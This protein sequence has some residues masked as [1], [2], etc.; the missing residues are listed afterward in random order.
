LATTV[1]DLLT[2]FLKTEVHEGTLLQALA[3]LKTWSKHFTNNLPASF[4]STI[5]TS[6]ALKS[7]TSSVRT[8]YFQLC[9][10]AIK[11]NTLLKGMELL[12]TL[13]QGIEKA[14][15]Q[16]HLA[17]SVLEA[18]S[19]SVCVARLGTLDELQGSSK[20]ESFW[21]TVT[22]ST[23]R[24]FTSDK[25]LAN[26]TTEGYEQ[27]ATFLQY[28]L[29]NRERLTDSSMKPFL[30][31]IV[32]VLIQSP[33]KQ[34]DVVKTTLKKAVNI[35]NISEDDVIMLLTELSSYFEEFAETADAQERKRTLDII[36]TTY[37]FVFQLVQTQKGKE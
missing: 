9:T 36:V 12:P 37:Q 22:D 32:N 1:F 2:P 26:I 15:A 19:A 35:S 11:G 17:S 25:F 20:I 29:A 33:W 34:R 6:I 30:T 28:L 23:K 5:Q 7:S 4:I 3:T 14:Q 18:L 24:L 13:L 21:T 16:A 27:L 31:V 8:L 10:E